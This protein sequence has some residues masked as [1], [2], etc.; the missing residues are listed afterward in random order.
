MLKKYKPVFWDKV[1]ILHSFTY[2]NINLNLLRIG[3]Q[4]L[5]R[6]YNIAR[7]GSVNA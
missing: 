6:A 2:D 4:F 3:R 7:L 5:L 1:F